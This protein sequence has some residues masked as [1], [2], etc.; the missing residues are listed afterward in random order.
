MYIE[1]LTLHCFDRCP[2]N[3]RDSRIAHLSFVILVTIPVTHA[4]NDTGVGLMKNNQIEISNLGNL[5]SSI[6]MI[7]YKKTTNSK[8]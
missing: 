3:S 1:N 8:I 7:F 5:T 4:V 6:S 2:V